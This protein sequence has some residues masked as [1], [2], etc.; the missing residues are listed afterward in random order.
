M[1]QTAQIIRED[2][3]LNIVENEQDNVVEKS[4]EGVSYYP[5]NN[6]LFKKV[7][8]FYYNTRIRLSFSVSDTYRSQYVMAR[9][10]IEFHR[11]KNFVFSYNKKQGLIEVDIN[12]SELEELQLFLST[13]LVWLRHENQF[14]LSLKI[15]LEFENRYKLER[16]SV[17]EL[18][19][20][21]MSAAHN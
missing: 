10:M 16:D 4:E 7:T 21:T 17:Y 8:H 20:N 9:G 3:Y 13:V 11:P 1:L 15:V 6:A 19:K 14:R 18:M 12:V 2:Q 5:I